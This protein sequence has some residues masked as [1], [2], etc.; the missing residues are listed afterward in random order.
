MRASIRVPPQGMF[1]SSYESWGRYGQSEQ[2]GVTLHWRGIVTP[3]AP[4]G[5]LAF[6]QGRSY[7]DVAQ[8][9]GG[10]LLS[11]RGLDRFIAFDAEQGVLRAEAGVRLCDILAL[12]VP[13]GWYLPVVPGTKYISL[14]G[15]VANDVHGKNHHRVG[16]FGHHVLSLELARSDGS[17]LICSPEQNAEWLAATIGGLGLTGLVTWV[18]VA[19]TRI[20]C[21]YADV[22]TIAVN[23]VAEFIAL[24][25]ASD[26]THEMTVGWF[27]CFSASGGKFRGLFSRANHVDQA[28]PGA[29]KAKP[30]LT[31]PVVPPVGVVHPGLMRLFNRA[32]YAAGMRNSGK[33]K[34]VPLDS[35]LYPL[36]RLDYWNRLYGPRGFLQLQCLIPHAN[37]EV[38]VSELLDVIASS[39]QGTLLAVIKQF[40]SRTSVGLLSFP[41]PGITV[42]LD[43][44]F[45]GDQTLE[46]F[47]RMHAVIRRYGGRLYPAKDACM[48]PADFA[49]SYPDWRRITPYLDP[50]FG[51]DFWRRVTAE[52]TPT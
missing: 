29:A 31:I 25:E 23:S 1:P 48:T 47:K 33:T 46:L 30:L 21:H 10:L 44:P 5:V 26:R 39:G 17:R 49:A 32:Y 11:T 3:T 50:A 6:G 51:S 37:A 9:T 2:R 45:L 35:F 52:S 22:E 40:G 14:G 18:E 41:R 43:F 4:G 42:A 38:G 8:N 15:A 7:G 36:D 28:R 16:T 20:G 19:L 13:H 24:C 27:D 12:T 34:R